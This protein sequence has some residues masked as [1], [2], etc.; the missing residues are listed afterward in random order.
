MT[1]K[2]YKTTMGQTVDMGALQIKNENVPAVGNMGV[3]ASGKK[4]EPSTKKA[5]INPNQIRTQNHRGTNVVK[6]RPDTSVTAAM[7]RIAAEKAEQAR[8]EAIRLEEEAARAALQS[9]VLEAIHIT[10]VEPLNVAADDTFD[11][12]EDFDAIG[13]EQDVVDNLMFSASTEI[14][15]L[16]LTLDSP[17]APQT[18]TTVTAEPAAGLAAAINRAKALK[19]DK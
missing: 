19:G 8:L 10:P 14:N 12:P 1:D 6:Q 4:I 9:S 13:V 3:T 18:K 11:E 7:E 15:P 17:A 2:T 16:D 5:E